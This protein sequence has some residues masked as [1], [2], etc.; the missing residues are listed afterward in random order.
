MLGQREREITRRVSIILSLP[1]SLIELDIDTHTYILR[2]VL[3]FGLL[4]M[5]YCHRVKEIKKWLRRSVIFSAFS[6][7]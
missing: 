2:T 1:L 6:Q 3:S 5:S 7:E 4:L